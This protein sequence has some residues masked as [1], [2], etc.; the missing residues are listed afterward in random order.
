MEKIDTYYLSLHSMTCLNRDV[1]DLMLLWNYKMWRTIAR[2]NRYYRDWFRRNV[3]SYIE[4]MIREM[5]V[6]SDIALTPIDVDGH[7]E[8]WFWMDG[9]NFHHSTFSQDKIDDH[10]KRIYAITIIVFKLRRNLDS[11][12]WLPMLKKITAMSHAFAL[13]LPT[14]KRA[15]KH[16]GYGG[17]K[18]CATVDFCPPVK[19]RGEYICIP[20][21]V[22]R[23]MKLNR[24][25]LREDIERLKY[26]ITVLESHLKVPA[27]YGYRNTDYVPRKGA[28][29]ALE[30]AKRYLRANQQK[31]REIKW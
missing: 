8:T 24:Q 16:L 15:A 30:N 13:T 21:K 20:R 9:Y 29:R 7:T 25:E 18:R 28:C 6:N 14:V 11:I 10:I 1:L 5:I 19:Y 26:E 27:I 12:L 4:M 3:D 17:I 31:L 23:G 2:V 22:A